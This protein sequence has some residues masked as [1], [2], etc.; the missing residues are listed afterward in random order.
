[1]WPRGLDEATVLIPSGRVGGKGGREGSK[2]GGRKRDQGGGE[3]AVD[4]WGGGEEIDHLVAVYHPDT[5][6]G[7]LINT[8]G[9]RAVRLRKRLHVCA[10][11]KAFL[12]L[13]A[14]KQGLVPSVC[15]PHCPGREG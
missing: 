10:C 15:S 4:K 2:V 9:V 5:G 6:S 13:G 1:M 7:C 8:G 11:T 14:W 12:T 3:V